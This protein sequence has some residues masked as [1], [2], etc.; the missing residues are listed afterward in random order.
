MPA[1]AVCLRQTRDDPSQGRASQ[2]ALEVDPSRR[3]FL[4]RRQFSKQRQPTTINFT[5]GCLLQYLPTKLHR[6]VKPVADQF[7][8]RLGFL[9]IAEDNVLASPL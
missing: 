8:P 9:N 7:A 3:R 1:G 4:H 2:A 6:R 5:V